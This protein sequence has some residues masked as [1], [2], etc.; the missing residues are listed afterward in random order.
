MGVGGY[1]ME[2][3]RACPWGSIKRRRDV[4]EKDDEKRIFEKAKNYFE[5]G[6]N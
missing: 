4:K 6:F 5:Q 1:F 2:V 3:P